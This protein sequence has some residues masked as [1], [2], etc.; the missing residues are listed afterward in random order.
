MKK[1]TVYLVLTILAGHAAFSQASIKGTVID[2]AEKRNLTNSVI[3]VMRQ[4]DSVLVKFTRTDKSGNFLLSDLPAGKFILQVSYPTYADYVYEFTVDNNNPIDLGKLSLI[5][6]AKLLEEVVV[7]QNIAIRIKGDTLEYKAD[8]FKVKEGATVEDLL[9]KLPGMQVNSK[10][11][12]TAQGEKVQKVLVDGEEFFSDDPAVVTKNLR[13]DALDKVQVFDK[14]SD[15]AT[16]TGI[17]DGEKSK[18]INLQL[19]EDKKKGYFGKVKIGGGTPGNYEG[20]GMINAFKGKRKISAFGTM[21]NTGKAGLNW[22]DADK[23]GGG[24]NMEYMEDEGYFVSFGSD[25]GLDT[26]GGRYNGQ[27]LP[28]AW[29]GGAHFS[30]KW[31]RD[32]SHINGNYQYYKQDLD[33]NEVTLSQDILGTNTFYNT[34]TKNSFN[35][36]IRNQIKSF[37]DWQ[38][39]SSTSVKFTLNGS[40]LRARS[41]SDFDSEKKNE[42][43]TL[44]NRQSRDVISDG[45]KQNLTA[46][47]LFRKRFN[48]KGRTLSLNLDNKF[49]KNHNSGFIRSNNEFF[50]RGVFTREDSVDQMKENRQ[51]SMA[52]NSKISYTEPIAK[53]TF[54]ELNYGYRSSNSEALRNSFNK[55]LGPNPKYEV[56]DSLFSNDYEFRV[57]THSGGLNFRYN[58]KK[59]NFSAGSNISS[60]DFEQRD[61]RKDT[62][63]SYNFVNL[64]PRANLRYT[65]G[66]QTRLNIGYNG[67]TRQ[68]TLEQIQPI[69]ENTDPLN[70]QV[71]NP[72]LKQEFRHNFNLNFNDYKV[73][74][75]RGIYL[76]MNVSFVDN[77]IGSSSL[78]SLNPDSIGKRTNSYVNIDGNYNA[79]VYSG[80]WF[81]WKKLNVDV[82]FNLNAGVSK[83]NSF[84][85][86]VKNSTDNRN[87][88][89]RMFINKNVENKYSF[90]LEPGANYNY[91]RSSINSSVVT[92]YWT[93]ESQVGTTIQLPLKM[94]FQ[95]EVTFF[96]R[97][98]TQ[99][100]N[101]NLNT[102]K[103]NAFVTKKFWKNNAG[104]IQLGVWDILNQNIGVNRNASSTFIMEQSYN[105]IRRYW[106]I[107]FQ[108]N[109]T[110]NPAMNN[111]ATK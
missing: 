98:K 58:G 67:S 19:K 103:W 1:L 5:P 36:N 46:M 42:D 23:F 72:N 38:I 30:N 31:N 68:P 63:Y 21:S 8:S 22:Q 59:L 15:Q 91:S 18:T 77:A 14:K 50:D 111:N 95:T 48:K 86:N 93:S 105:T 88:G 20:E 17:D 107:S 71:G 106:L 83:Y 40:D 76:G 96:L 11:E 99:V 2:T 69:R 102:T 66:P 79:N 60:A 49:D 37:Y 7:R 55:S 78:V 16:F 12:I 101:R 47:I 26:W 28:K 82:N 92:K 13:A 3:V 110:R 27:G 51:E 70:I 4:N 57:N 75:N 85:N 33:I 74:A 34:Q 64:F 94:E 53:N 54:L 90:Y 81:K 73:I 84:V 6:K 9:K 109:F 62:S 61:L 45:E 32:R 65:I 104:E 25:D 89:L 41:M 100:F 44:A 56:R 97:Q 35:Q 39:D 10:G 80:L 24:N 108:W 29:Q 52:F 87:V 43:G